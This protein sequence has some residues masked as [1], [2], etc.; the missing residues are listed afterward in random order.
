MRHNTI[1]L[2]IQFENV[3]GTL[4]EV[5]ARMAQF[6]LDRPFEFQFLDETFDGLYRAE[7]CFG[8]IA[9]YLTLLALF[10]AGL[11]LIGFTASVIEQRTKE[12]GIRKL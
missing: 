8:S 4:E 11:G 5:E 7:E 12:I 1:S 2:I 9:G 3:S 10:L 6:A